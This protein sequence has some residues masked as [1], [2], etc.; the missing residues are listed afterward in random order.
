MKE[1]E[2]DAE[3]YR[4]MAADYLETVSAG[5]SCL[6]VS[7]THAE[8]AAITAEIR[9]QL[10][11]A[12]KL[13]G[14]ERQFSRLVAVQASEA[15]RGQATTYRAGDVLQWHQNAA[16]GVV[17]GQ[18]TVVGDPAAVPVHLADRFSLYRAEPIS[19]AVG[20]KIRFTGNV[21]AWGKAEHK[22]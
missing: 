19:L 1:I 16:G 9:R 10:R 21:K 12:G 6:V 2:E 11:L 20:D 5:A 17:R 4:A 18:R 13:G 22:L 8:A 15:E 14:E 7:P 3:R